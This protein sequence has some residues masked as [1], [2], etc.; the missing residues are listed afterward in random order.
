V[1]VRNISTPVVRTAAAVAA[2]ALLSAACGSSDDKASSGS[3]NSSSC[4]KPYKLGV[5]L[6]LTGVYAAVSEPEKKAIEMYAE[7]LNA[8]GGING[9]QVELTYVDTTSDEGAAVN[10]VRKL[11]TE[12]KVIGIVGPSSSGEAIAVKPIVESLKVPT[13]AVAAS[14]A[15]ITAPVSYMFKEFTASED[16]LQAQLV[17][18]KSQNLTKVGMLY[19]NNGYGQ[20]PAAALKDLAK[21]AGVEVVASEAFP[22]AATDVTSQLS[23][24]AKAKPDVILVWAVNPA[25]A[26]VAKNAKAL[27]L[28]AVLFQAPGAASTAYTELGGKDVEGTLVQASK[29]LVAD[30]V[31][32]E[33]PQYAAVSGF[34]KDYKAKYGTA[35]S[36]FAGGGY[37][38]ILLM[39][40]AL[41]K[42]KI[43]PCA[44]VQ[45]SRDALRDSLQNN[46]KDVAGTITVYN[47]DDKLH[48]PKGIVGQAV[49]KVVGGKFTLEA[50][51]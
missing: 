29:V 48:G 30:S 24:V 6:G 25:N 4:S 36:Q 34:A 8:K 10:T 16:S 21:A 27:G 33:D 17:Y 46:I 9:H 12:D 13:M 47:F 39:A 11:A 5:A 15:I 22:P 41:E 40:T 38:S 2:L 14:N 43:D 7:Q 26:I 42:G 49:L 51:N 20:G 45:T 44:D 32:P 50:S 3:T 28:S 19:S 1:R 18:A 37:D 31:K 35:P 23:A